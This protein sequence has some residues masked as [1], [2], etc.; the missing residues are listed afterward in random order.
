[1]LYVILNNI[2]NNNNKILIQEWDYDKNNSNY[3]E[4]VKPGE[5]L[6]V[7]FTDFI[8]PKV[9]VYADGERLSASEYTYE[10]KKFS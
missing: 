8:P 4:L 5:E 1:M 2:K 9:V 3:V 6:K 7:E 10:N